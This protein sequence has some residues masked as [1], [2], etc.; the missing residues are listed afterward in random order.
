MSDAQYHVFSQSIGKGTFGTVYL[1]L[2]RTSGKLVAVKTEPKEKA[3]KKFLHHENRIMQQLSA[4]RSCASPAGACVAQLE[5]FWEDDSRYYLAMN[6]MGPSIDHLHRLCN[7]SFSLK[8]T[9]M[10]ID[11]MLTLIEYHH[12]RNIVHRDIKPANFLVSYEL[13]HK[14][15]TL[16]D[17]GLARKASTSRA[18]N[19]TAPQAGT[20]RYMSKNIHNGIEASYR[21]DMYSLGYCMIYLFTGALAWKTDGAGGDGGDGAAAPVPPVQ[22]RVQRRKAVGQLKS[23]ITNEQLTAH[24]QCIRCQEDRKECCFRTLL[25]RYFNHI[26]TLEFGQMANYSWVRNELQSCF[27][28]HKFQ[29]DYQWDWNKYYLVR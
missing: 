23:S 4:S 16:V 15:I 7:R 1:G 22:D 13:P 25:V 12:L 14:Q 21:D 10:V 19:F 18:N 28:S 26:D 29:Y 11:Q 24:C 17:Y 27:R 2:N 9:L 5:Q 6:L 8:T 3:G 20:L